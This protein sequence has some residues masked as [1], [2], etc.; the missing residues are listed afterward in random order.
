SMNK[1]AALLL[2]LA[3]SLRGYTQGPKPDDFN[4]YVTP[5]TSKLFVS[6]VS[7][8]SRLDLANLRAM[9][10]ASGEWQKLKKGEGVTRPG[11]GGRI[12][13]TLGWQRALDPEHWVADYS[14][15]WIA[16]SSSSSDIIHVLELRDGKV[17]VTQEIEADTHHG[18][19]AVGAWF[20]SNK[21]LL[22]V[23][24]VNYAPGE[25]RCCPSLMG[26]VTFRWNGKQFRPMRAKRVP[27]P[28]D[29]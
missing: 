8:F 5:R 27:L 28:P 2:L 10:I 20:D 16:G 13:V 22:T 4:V 24:A 14:W 29:N 26:V 18:G 3:T 17:Y 9:H 21:K 25:G 1:F 7:D 6:G 23:K 11:E 19:K 15:I 12:E